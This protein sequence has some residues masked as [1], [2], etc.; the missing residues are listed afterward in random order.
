MF[1]SGKSSWG[2]D[3]TCRVQRL[4][5]QQGHWNKTEAQ[6]TSSQ[7]PGGFF[8]LSHA[9]GSGSSSPT[10]G[11][12][13][14]VYSKDKT[15]SVCPQFLRVRLFWGA[16]GFIPCARIPWRRCLQACPRFWSSS[17]CSGTCPLLRGP[18]VSGDAGRNSRSCVSHMLHR[19]SPIHSTQKE[20]I[21][22]SIKA[23]GTYS[24]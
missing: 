20:G 9:V 11:A 19:T 14:P 2:S 5:H 16:L 24:Q 15:L 22:P 21:A 12:S 10:L 13:S 3:G 1:S 17:C 18:H 23:L 7:A 6:T 4:R 8:P